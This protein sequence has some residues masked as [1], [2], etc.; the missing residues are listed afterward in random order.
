[1]ILS[2]KTSGHKITHA[3]QE[4]TYMLSLQGC[5]L[6]HIFGYIALF[7][8]SMYLSNT[9]VYLSFIMLGKI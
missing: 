1:M 8:T 3:T 9:K 2:C 6:D 7:L 5:I 4:T